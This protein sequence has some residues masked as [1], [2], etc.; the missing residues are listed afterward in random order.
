ML[1]KTDLQK[2]IMPFSKEGKN[3]KETGYGFILSEDAYDKT[4][5]L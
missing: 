1:Q 3:T 2:T 5:T 4:K